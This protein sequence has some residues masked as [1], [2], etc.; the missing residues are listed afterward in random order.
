MPMK[1]PPHPGLSARHDCLEPLGLTVTEGA[2][3]LRVSRQALNS[4][5]SGKAGISPE[6]AIRLDK[7]FGGT[8]DAWLALQSAY[9][10][11]QARKAAAHIHVKRYVARHRP[12]EPRSV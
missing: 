11:T 4:L 6:M 8:A 7:A 12:R 3:V 5:V 10:L 2:K 1:D 9:D